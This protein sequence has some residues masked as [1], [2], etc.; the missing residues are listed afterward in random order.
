MKNYI[1]KKYQLIL[2]G[3]V[4]LVSIFLSLK[5]PRYMSFL[6]LSK[7]LDPDILKIVHDK[8]LSRPEAVE[9]MVNMYKY[10][11]DESHG[12]SLIED[13]SFCP[14]PSDAESND[15]YVKW[16]QPASEY[17]YD[18]E[19]VLRGI[20]ETLLGNGSYF[21]DR[22][23][24]DSPEKLLI[25]FNSKFSE[26]NTIALEIGNIDGAQVIKSVLIGET[27]IFDHTY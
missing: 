13:D 2:F 20:L 22:F 19:N 11:Y 27:D 3:V 14:E 6:E 24:Q 26:R 12:C 10:S 21:F 18:S 15:I 9:I 17:R 16:G 23:S 7:K 5:V 25:M 4:I 8:K 1:C